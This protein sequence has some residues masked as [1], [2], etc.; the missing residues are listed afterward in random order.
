MNKEEFML[1]AFYVVVIC[2]GFGTL[3]WAITYDPPTNP[4]TKK[5]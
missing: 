4:P 3:Y 1:I 5:K 2:F